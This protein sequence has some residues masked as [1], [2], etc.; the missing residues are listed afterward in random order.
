[1]KVC[2]VA[3]MRQMDK[4]ATDIYG[5]SPE[6]LM[7][8]AGE[9]VYDVIQ[10]EG[11]ANKKFVVLCGPGNNGGDGFVVARKLHSRGGEVKVFL[12]AERAKYQG[13]AKNN[14]EIIDRFPL[15][16][17]EITAIR[18]IKKDIAAADVIVD[19]LLGTG[20]DRNVEGLLHQVIETVNTSGKKVFAVD[21]AS[22]INGDNGREMGSSIKADATITF[23]LPKLGN[24]LYPGYNRGGKLYL[25]HISFPRSLYESDKINVELAKPIRLPE[26]R[27]M[28]T[29][30]IT[31]RY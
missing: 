19:A 2:R 14:L 16:I 12:F 1:M 25:S 6:I 24:L 4:Q 15:D 5:I 20:L 8:N 22:G 7:E 13:T 9:A 23:G 30:W 17:K 18:Q 26:R 31:G 10:K 21:I 3:E 29:K 28:P 11:V 27:R